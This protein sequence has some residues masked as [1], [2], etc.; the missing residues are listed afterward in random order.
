MPYSSALF[1]LLYTYFIGDVALCR[2]AQYATNGH[3]LDQDQLRQQK[4][5]VGIVKIGSYVRVCTYMPNQKRI[6]HEGRVRVDSGLLAKSYL[7]SVLK[8][9][10]NR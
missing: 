4:A 6:N 1:N 9:G 10:A 5:G 2:T 8:S 3:K 7:E